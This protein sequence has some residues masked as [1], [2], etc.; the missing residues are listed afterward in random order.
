MVF[1]SLCFLG[2]NWGWERTALALIHGLA[3]SRRWGK[4]WVNLSLWEA[5]HAPVSPPAPHQKAFWQASLLP[6][7]KRP[8]CAWRLALRAWLSR[9]LYWWPG[10]GHL[11]PSSAL[12]W[13]FS[14]FPSSRQIC[15]QQLPHGQHNAGCHEGCQRNGGC[16]PC[17]P[18]ETSLT[19][20]A[21]DP[22]RSGDVRHV[23]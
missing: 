17:S 1:P 18:G 21:L 22:G 9:C 10:V 8:F 12:L 16:S 3:Q 14:H 2:L 6:T 15:V 23:A 7:W 4:D 5:R 11:A 13:S 19:G 20:W